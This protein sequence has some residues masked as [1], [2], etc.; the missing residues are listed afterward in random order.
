MRTIG[1]DEFCVLVTLRGDA[2]APLAS[3]LA[4]ALSEHG[5]G[6]SIDASYGWGAL[7]LEAAD[8][9]SALRLVDQRMYAQKQGGRA[10]ARSQSKDVLVQALLERSPELTEHLSVVSRMAGATARRLGLDEAERETIETAGALHDI[11]KFAIPDAILDKP[12]PLDDVEWEYVKR[13]SAIGERIVAAAPALAGVAKLVRSTHEHVDGSGYPDGLTGEQI[14]LGARVLAVC[15][16]YDAMTSGDRPYRKAMDPASAL[17]E[18]RR[19]AGTQFD[20]SVV[21]AF[22]A[23]DAS[24]ELETHS[25]RMTLL[26]PRAGLALTRA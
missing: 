13:H 25:D 11:G 9:E 26:D 20:P 8:P 17:A 14:P 15:D 3:R 16:A 10:S 2:P 1:G 4:A 18:L 24:S 7:P 19:C 22:L 21:E 5:D 12:G 6:F 23:A